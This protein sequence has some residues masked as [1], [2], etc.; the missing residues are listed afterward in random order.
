[1]FARDGRLLVSFALEGMVRAMA[2][3]SSGA[4]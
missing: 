3:N 2:A 4:L 1:V